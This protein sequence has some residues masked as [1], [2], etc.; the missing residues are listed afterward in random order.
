[1]SEFRFKRSI[2][3]RERGV[4]GAQAIQPGGPPDLAL[5]APRE[6]S[7]GECFAPHL[8]SLFWIIFNSFLIDHVSFYKVFMKMDMKI[9]KVGSPSG[10]SRGSPEK[11][12]E[13]YV[14]S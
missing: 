12:K 5:M 6:E 11:M 3:P 7:E 13:N 2:R 10:M 4:K 1:M 14:C 9:A 8:I